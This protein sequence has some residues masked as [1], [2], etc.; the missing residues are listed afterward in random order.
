MTLVCSDLV[1]TR[2]QLKA[3]TSNS[4]ENAVDGST[5]NVAEWEIAMSEDVLNSNEAITSDKVT[6]AP[7]VSVSGD[8]C[9]FP[10]DGREELPCTVIKFAL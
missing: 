9:E 2:G 8:A 6:V 1:S 4:S 5:I 3:I 7:L 10:G